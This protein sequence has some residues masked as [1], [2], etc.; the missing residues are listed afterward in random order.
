MTYELSPETPP[1][2]VDENDHGYLPSRRDKR[3]TKRYRPVQDGMPDQAFH[4]EPVL[5]PEYGMLFEHQGELLQNLQR[6][7]LFVALKLPTV[8]E[9]KLNIPRFPQCSQYGYQRSAHPDPRHDNEKLNDEMIHQDICHHFH[10]VYD[11]WYIDLYEIQQRIEAKINTSLP[12]VL[13]NK[14][15]KKD[16]YLAVEL[17]GQTLFEESYYETSPTGRTKREVVTA[18]ISALGALGGMAIRGINAWID[19]RKTKAMMK[20][21]QSLYDNQDIIHNQVKILHNRTSMM[22]KTVF[23][24]LEAVKDSLNDTNERL[25]EVSTRL[26]A[27]IHETNARFRDTYRILTHHHLSFHFIMKFL[28]LYITTLTRH[29]D[30]LIQYEQKV[31][32]LNYALDQLAS[33]RLTHT[34]LDPAKLKQYLQDIS[35]DLE[36]T[37]PDYELVFTY[38]WQY[39]AYKLISYTNTPTQLLIQI[40]ILIKLKVQVPMSLF[41]VETVPVPLDEETYNGVEHHY[42]QIIHGSEYLAMTPTNYI[43][44][45]QAQ[46]Q[47]CFRLAFTYYC[48]YAHLLRT[49]SEHTCASAIYYDEESAIIAEHCETVVH[50]NAPPTPRILDAGHQLVLSNLPKPWQIHCATARH[51]VSIKYS[52]YRIINRTELCECSLT[53]GNYL[54]EQS[55]LLCD[56]AATAKDGLFTTYYVINRIIFDKLENKFD[57]VLEEEF[58]DLLSRLH[59]DVPYYNL[60]DLDIL[61][62]RKRDNVLNENQEKAYAQ[63]EHVLVHMVDEQDETLFLSE[64]DY[65]KGQQ[66]FKTYMESAELWRKAGYL[67]SWIGTALSVFALLA[68]AYW[69]C[70]HKHYIKSLITAHYASMEVAE[71]YVV[72]PKPAQTATIPT[73]KPLFTLNPEFEEETDEELHDVATLSTAVFIAIVIVIA[74][75]IFSTLYAVYR[76]CRHRSALVRAAFPWFPLST[77]IRG[78]FRSDIFVEITNRSKGSAI[79]AHFKTVGVYP[80]SLLV[81]G[82]LQL[83]DI[84]ITPICCFKRIG[85]NWRNVTITDCTGFTYEMPDHSFASIFTEHDL[86]NFNPEDQY[87]IRIMG[88]ILDLIMELPSAPPDVQAAGSSTI[89]SAPPTHGSAAAQPPPYH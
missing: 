6:K 52:T 10:D 38:V 72:V 44:M 32:D 4:P 24:T 79:W 5:K 12:A 37:A 62:P 78:K 64:E 58:K 16:G 40:P 66:N 76:K 46:L 19:N 60:P 87:D 43:P 74:L 55:P 39:Y 18:V 33:G 65:Q 22:A 35:D 54:L 1:S 25:D 21:M 82:A 57:V 61:R 84:T 14:V 86:T 31:D 30:H 80:T 17:Q 88:R 75:M 77:I 47:L 7:Y 2:E 56:M 23:T 11:Q 49:R 3:D 85:I 28:S 69:F 83:D 68:L 51:A 50:L 42:T 81:T 48:E 36:D 27:Y 73:L 20:A 15:V 71:D 53:A 29:K 89:S 41:S 34:V 13:P 59:N 63:L 8:D 70:T 45:T 9:L 67:L 26:Y